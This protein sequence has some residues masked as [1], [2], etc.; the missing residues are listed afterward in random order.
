MHILTKKFSQTTTI[1]S[2]ASMFQAVVTI[3][4]DDIVK[5]HKSK[6][7]D[8]VK[9]VLCF[10]I[11]YF[12]DKTFKGLGSSFVSFATYIYTYFKIEVLHLVHNAQLVKCFYCELNSEYN[13]TSYKAVGLVSLFS[14]L[15]F[16]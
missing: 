16:T 6:D 4:N 11:Q 15:N 3:C 1:I 2:V 9:S 5:V 14:R 12:S 10:I 7:S 13:I 8:I